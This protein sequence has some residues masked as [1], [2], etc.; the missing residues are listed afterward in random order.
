MDTRH[1]YAAH[2][3]E[4]TRLRAV[5]GTV[6]DDLPPGPALGLA[7]LRPPETAVR[8]EPRTGTSAA[9]LHGSAVIRAVDC[10]AETARVDDWR[11]TIGKVL[12]AVDWPAGTNVD[13]HV[14][15]TARRV[16]L[17][18]P[19]VAS[20][21]CSCDCPHRDAAET[22]QRPPIPGVDDV[23]D[24]AV[25]VQSRGRVKLPRNLLKLLGATRDGGRITA[26]TVADL[27]AVLLVGTG[28]YL[29]RLLPDLTADT[30]APAPSNV[31][32]L[33]PTT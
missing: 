6:E 18:Q 1:G 22:D 23:L 3:R 24:A 16:W 21:P 30:G 5:T 15:L 12:A 2:L 27:D 8:P 4:Q 14:D 25:N 7:R 10:E 9:A 20:E 31:I 32:D 28:D 33:H 19:H 17:R 29:R 11:I 13:A 26:T